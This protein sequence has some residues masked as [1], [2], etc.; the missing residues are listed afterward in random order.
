MKT[1]LHCGKAV[2]GKA[3]SPHCVTDKPRFSGHAA[4]AAGFFRRS[5]GQRR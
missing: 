5:A 4:A 3:L 2:A 1:T